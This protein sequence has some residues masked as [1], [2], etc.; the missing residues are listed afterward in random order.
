MKRVSRIVL[1][2]SLPAFILLLWWLF[3]SIGAVPRQILPAPQVVWAVYLNPAA[4]GKMAGHLLIS[5]RRVFI[6]FSAASVIGVAAGSLT[7]VSKTMKAVILPTLTAVRQIPIIAWVP[8]I[9]LWFGIGE[10]AKVV[11]IVTAAFFV[12][13][14]NT[15]A[16]IS[17]TP[18]EYLELARLYKLSGIRT[19]VS[20]NLPC[21]LPNILTGLQLGLGVSWMAVVA[22]ELISATSGIGY[23]M[24]DA[25]FQLR[26]DIMIACMLVI[27][28]VGVLMNT[29]LT[30]LFSKVMPWNSR[31]GG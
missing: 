8:L 11:I 6:G 16:G 12:I 17:E 1:G 14:V 15:H 7:G 27:G 19:F 4:R 5:L 26:P 25:R 22:S 29:A 24:N 2:L 21:A 20:V 30:V 18:E 31:E 28:I 3:T 9:I 13:Y 23:Y 10:I